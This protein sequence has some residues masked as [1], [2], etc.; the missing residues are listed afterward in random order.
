[1]TTV[2]V[3][4]PVQ[5]GKVNLS[6]GPFETPSIGSRRKETSRHIIRRHRKKAVTVPQDKKLGPVFLLRQRALV[7]C[8]GICRWDI[9]LFTV[10]VGV[11]R[12]HED[13]TEAVIFECVAEDTV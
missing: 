12:L 4:G 3:D 1:M 13:R 9:R 5:Q 7:K 10:Q 8:R 6:N 11:Q 2:G